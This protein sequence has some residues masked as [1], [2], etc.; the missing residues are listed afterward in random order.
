MGWGWGI[1]KETDE[2]SLIGAVT[3]SLKFDRRVIVEQ[4]I[5]AKEIEVAVLGNDEPTCSV[6]GEI[7]LVAEFYDYEAKYKDDNTELVIPAKV[8]KEVQASMEEMSILAYK[9][10]DCAGLVRSDF[11]VTAD[12]QVL[13]NEVNTMPGL[14]P[15]SMFTLLWQTQGF[16]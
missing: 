4:G 16:K 5:D 2:A 3:L 10:L 8:S 9:V 14:P 13:I 1:G 12:D 11:F 15:T 6:S 7:K